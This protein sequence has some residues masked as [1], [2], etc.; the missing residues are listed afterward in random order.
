M[1]IKLEQVKWLPNGVSFLILFIN[2]HIK[3]Q[4]EK[5]KKSLNSCERHFVLCMLNYY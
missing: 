1:A 3:F 2:I 4:G 5:E